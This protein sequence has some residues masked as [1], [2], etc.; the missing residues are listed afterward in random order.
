MRKPCVTSTPEHA[1]WRNMHLRC[2]N[3]DHPRYHRYGGRGIVVCDRWGEFKYY[4][5]DMGPRPSPD[6]SLDRIDN[7]G[8]YAPWNCRW[9]TRA[10]QQ[11]NRRKPPG[12]TSRH[13]G[14]SWH[15]QIGR[16]RATV[17]RNNKQISLGCYAT[18]VEAAQAVLQYKESE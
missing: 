14:V 10:Q 18:E 17:V 5:A 6:H 15:A 9:A 13:N 2:S 11:R 4:Y 7:D 1:A 3:P 16:W 8:P 12:G